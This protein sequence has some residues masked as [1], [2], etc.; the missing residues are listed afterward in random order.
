LAISWR[1]LKKRKEK[2]MKVIIT[3]HP[4]PSLDLAK[5]IFNKNGI[6]MEVL[7]TRDP[8]TKSAEDVVRALKG[9][10]PK[11]VVNPEAFHAQKGTKQG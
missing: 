10:M 9:E 8:E 7:Q 11:N 4:F 2:S 1:K 6:E 3:D 5:E